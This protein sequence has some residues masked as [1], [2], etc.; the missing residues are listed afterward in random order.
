MPEPLTDQMSSSLG[1]KSVIEMG[2]PSLVSGSTHAS[3]NSSS[4]PPSMAWALRGHG[5]LGVEMKTLPVNK[6]FACEMAREHGRGDGA[7][8]HVFR[9]ES[10]HL[11]RAREGDGGGGI[12]GRGRLGCRR[13][14]VSLL[15]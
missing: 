4:P 14:S 10:S 12:G 6:N 1:S 2:A 3:L 7:T 5:V 13:A 11:A 8:N 15:L 9:E